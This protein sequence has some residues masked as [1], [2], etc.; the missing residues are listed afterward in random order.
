MKVDGSI[1]PM[2]DILKATQLCM[3]WSCGAAKGSLWWM[4]QPIRLSTLKIWATR[5][6]RYLLIWECPSILILRKM[7]SHACVVCH[8]KPGANT[9]NRHCFVMT[10]RYSCVDGT[11]AAEDGTLLYIKASLNANEPA[12]VTQYAKTHPEFPHEST[13]NQFFNEAQ[14]ESYVRLGAHIVEEIMAGG[15]WRSTYASS[16]DDLFNAAQ[17]KSKTLAAGAG[18]KPGLFNGSS[19][20]SVT[21]NPS[22]DTAPDFAAW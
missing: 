7:P 1:F 4:D 10:I 13:A 14:F 9:N 2:A 6:E 20:S 19:S 18:K 3:K 11:P 15:P 8:Y 5:Y 17:G 21:C 12:D 16:L 22:A